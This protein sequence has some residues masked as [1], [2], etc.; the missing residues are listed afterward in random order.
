MPPPAD[1]KQ[2]S[3]FVVGP[4]GGDGSEERRKADWL[5]HMII[6]PALSAE[7]FQYEVKRADEFADPGMIT[8]QVIA[9]VLEADL[10]IADLTGRN[11][12]AFYELAIRHMVEKPAIHMI[13]TGELPPFDVRD[14]RLIEYK[15]A[16][17]TDLQDAIASV[18]R[19]AQAI[20][21]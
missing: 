9:A 20:E 11:P 5:L 4:I 1:Q 2:R 13:E 6:R 18:Q 14:Y 15:L 21:Q 16:H 10:V 19:H 8:S 7:P 12:N 17:P 3:C